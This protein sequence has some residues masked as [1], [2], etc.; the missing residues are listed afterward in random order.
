MIFSIN[1]TRQ[2][3]NKVQFLSLIHICVKT[4]NFTVIYKA[5]MPSILLEYAFYTNKS[6]IKILKN[7]VDDLVAVSYTHLM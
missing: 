3:L 2:K 7:N 5:Q 1:H 6:D 4:E